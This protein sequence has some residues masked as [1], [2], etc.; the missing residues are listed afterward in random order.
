LLKTPQVMSLVVLLPALV[1]CT[2]FISQRQDFFYA[3]PDPFSLFRRYGFQLLCLLWSIPGLL[4]YHTLLFSYLCRINRKSSC[5]HQIQDFS[6]LS[7]FY[8]LASPKCYFWLFH[9]DLFQLLYR[10]P[11]VEHL[12]NFSTPPFIFGRGEVTPA[13]EQQ[14]VIAKW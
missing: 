5:G 2:H 12:R 13:N 3:R 8:F 7:L 9:L 6:H 4:P 14:V 1:K 11:T 10:G